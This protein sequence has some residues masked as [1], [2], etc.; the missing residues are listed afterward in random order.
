MVTFTGEAAATEA[1]AIEETLD[2]IG[3]ISAT[4]FGSSLA[5][6][7]R[8]PAITIAPTD[9]KV[10]KVRRLSTFRT[11]LD[12]LSLSAICIH[13]DFSG[14]ESGVIGDPFR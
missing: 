1:E 3:V 14:F 11:L 10:P 7:K 4:A 13:S 8:E 9:A 5:L 12:T 6:A 2:V